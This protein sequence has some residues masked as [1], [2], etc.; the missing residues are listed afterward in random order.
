M[1]E[2]KKGSAV[3]RIHGNA[4]PDIKAITEQFIKK[5]EKQRKRAKK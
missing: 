5:A 3:I 2:I 1:Q 4:S